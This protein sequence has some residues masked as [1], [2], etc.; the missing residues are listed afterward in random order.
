MHS[1]YNTYT[2]V[3]TY[4]YTSTLWKMLLLLKHKKLYTDRMI[5]CPHANFQSRNLISFNMFEK[6]TLCYC[7]Q[8][9]RQ[10]LLNNE[11][12]WLP[13]SIMHSIIY[14]LP[15]SVLT[16]RPCLIF[17]PKDICAKHRIMRTKITE[18]SFQNWLQNENKRER[19]SNCLFSNTQQTNG[20]AVSGFLSFLWWGWRTL[21][22]ARKKKEPLFLFPSYHSYLYLS[23]PR[24]CH[25]LLQ[26]PTTVDWLFS[27][28]SKIVTKSI[29]LCSRIVILL[30]FSGGVG[31]LTSRAPIKKLFLKRIAKTTFS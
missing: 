4:M 6:V 10:G 13:P 30:V 15:H 27:S 7:V 11:R 22:G 17:I 31:S 8:T 14:S 28:C 9:V 26:P 2:A 20:I 5:F 3:H 21:E 18:N 19:N 24:H 12:P 16:F 29:S 23:S 25:S 1:I